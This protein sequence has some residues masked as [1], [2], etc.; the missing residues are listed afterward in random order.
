MKWLPDWGHRKQ[1]AAVYGPQYLNYATMPLP[2]YPTE[3]EM[4]E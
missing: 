1:I 3:D 2:N 4:H